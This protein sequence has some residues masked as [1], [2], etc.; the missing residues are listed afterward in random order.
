[1]LQDSIMPQDSLSI[2]FC[3]LCQHALFLPHFDQEVQLWID[4]QV[5]AVVNKIMKL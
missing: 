3:V 5:I 4:M 1:M 2:W